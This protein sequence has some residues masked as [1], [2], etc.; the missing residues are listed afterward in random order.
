MIFEQ[1]FLYRC[2]SCLHMFYKIDTVKEKELVCPECKSGEIEQ[3]RQVI[4]KDFG[5]K[6]EWLPLSLQCKTC[7][8]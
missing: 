5:I 3:V 2:L 6:A 4:T 1:R 8:K 7:D